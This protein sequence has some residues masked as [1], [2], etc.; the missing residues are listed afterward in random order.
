M[1]KYGLN[2]REFI[3]ACALYFGLKIITTVR[4]N[5]DFFLKSKR[6][7]LFN[8]A[9]T[10][11]TQSMATALILYSAHNKVMD[12]C[13]GAIEKCII[14]PH[15]RFQYRSGGAQTDLP[16]FESTNPV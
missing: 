1:H 16:F 14:K 5:G 7:D 12:R 9:C 8:Q 15:N 2:Q 10:V 11:T 3:I 13:R 6:Y 4:H